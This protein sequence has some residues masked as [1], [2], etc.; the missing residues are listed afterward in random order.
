MFGCIHCENT[1]AE[2]SP[3][4]PAEIHHE[5]RGKRFWNQGGDSCY[6]VLE[7]ISKRGLHSGETANDAPQERHTYVPDRD[8]L[9]LSFTRNQSHPRIKPVSCPRHSLTSPSY[10]VPRDL[11]LQL[12]DVTGGHGLILNLSVSSFYQLLKVLH[13]LLILFV[14]YHSLLWK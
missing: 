7:K 1:G 4:V 10:L 2:D 13:F 11:G 8:N 9:P 12:L 3:W 6:W 5:W 14:L